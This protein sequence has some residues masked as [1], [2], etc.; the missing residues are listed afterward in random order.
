MLFLCTSINFACLDSTIVEDDKACS[1]FT[2]QTIYFRPCLFGKK[3]G[4]VAIDSTY[5]Y[6][7]SLGILKFHG[8]SCNMNTDYYSNN[9]L[10]TTC[11]GKADDESC[12]EDYER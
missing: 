8:D 5:T 2:P 11:V 4:T 6:C 7:E 9:C 3:C 10:N 1:H 12:K